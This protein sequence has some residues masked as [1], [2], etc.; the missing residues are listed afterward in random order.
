[1]SKNAF[2]KHPTANA[3]AKALIT[4][5][6]C[7]LCCIGIYLS[8]A[9]LFKL[10]DGWGLGPGCFALMVLILGPALF[11][12]IFR[13]AAGLVGGIPVLG[14]LAFLFTSNRHIRLSAE[15]ATGHLEKVVD[16]TEQSAYQVIEQIQQIDGTVENLIGSVTEAIGNIGAFGKSWL[17]GDGEK[18]NALDS[19]KN[20]AD[21]RLSSMVD[22]EEH[23]QTVVD[24]VSSLA[25]STGVIKSIAMQTHMLA[26]NATVEAARAGAYGATFAVVADEVRKLAH[27]ANEAAETI[28]LRVASI[29]EVLEARIAKRR[30]ESE[31]E[32][33]V[34]RRIR[35]QHTDL[36]KDYSDMHYL[37]EKSMSDMEASSRE[38]A[39]LVSNAL[40][41]IQFQ[42]IVRQKIEH[43]IATL[44]SL[45]TYQAGS[46]GRG[47]RKSTG[48]D[49]PN[50]APRKSPPRFD[51]HM[52]SQRIVHEEVTGEKVMEEGDE[53]PSIE[54]F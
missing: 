23:V 8:A 39:S 22:Y 16:D 25:E 40:A 21:E 45:G 2:K 26:L 9:P 5:F 12:L 44:A 20:H 51:Y 4:A 6:C 42:D 43:V 41:N 38:I 13:T 46:N 3:R 48:T 47:R 14:P 30:Q 50:K 28:E 19:F 18:N 31:R 1:M 27:I 17:G 33:D 11:V 49:N 54:L 32:K 10:F 37:Y 34:L 29:T 52:N 15:L 36:L 24:Q 35:D 53:G 7:L